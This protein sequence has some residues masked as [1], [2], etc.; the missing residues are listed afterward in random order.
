MTTSDKFQEGLEAKSTSSGA[1]SVPMSTA[2]GLVALLIAQFAS[3]PIIENTTQYSHGGTT[4]TVLEP[5]SL[6]AS[7]LDLFVQINRVYDDLLNN[8]VEL[9]SESKQALYENLWD[10]YG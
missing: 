2:F 3:Q 7:T 8:Q 9:D 5:E 1:V 4:G 6:N 10:L